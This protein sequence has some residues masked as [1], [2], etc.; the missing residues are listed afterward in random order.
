MAQQPRRVQ[1]VALS[2]DAP[3]A[4]A[5]RATLGALD[6]ED[7]FAGLGQFGL[8]H[9]DIGNIERDRDEWMLGHQGSSFQIKSQSRHDCASSRPTAQPLHLGAPTATPGEPKYFAELPN[10]PH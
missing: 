9:A 10:Y 1:T 2:D 3:A 5:G 7:E 4:A 6:G 8:E